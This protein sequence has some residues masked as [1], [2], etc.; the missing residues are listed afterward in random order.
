[1]NVNH[2]IKE[3]KNKEI[4]YQEHFVANAFNKFF[5]THTKIG[6]LTF[7][8]V[9]MIYGATVGA[10]AR[11]YICFIIINLSGLQKG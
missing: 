9:Y 4:C 5:F 7:Y 2:C 11:G 10:C 3:K 6:F 1:M 8:E